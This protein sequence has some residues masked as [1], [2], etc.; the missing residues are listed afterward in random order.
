M[1]KTVF[2]IA[3]FILFTVCAQGEIKDGQTVKVF[4][5]KNKFDL[6]A[7]MTSQ[8]HAQGLS[9][10]KQMPKDGMIFIF[11]QARP[12]V[13]WMK[14]M[15]FAIDIIWIKENKIIG[16]VQNAPPEPKKPDYLLKKYF[17][18]LEADTVIELNAG[19]IDKFGIKTEDKVEIQDNRQ[20]V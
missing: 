19:D 9:G 14:D 3:L 13:F 17:S 4:I 1:K 7:A 16:F 8:S 5:N 10:R 18:P 11:G 12:L 2:I 6:V 20:K 15:N